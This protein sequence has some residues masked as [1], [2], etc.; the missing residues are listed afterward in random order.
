MRERD[1]QQLVVEAAGYLGWR[2][3]HDF[4]SR[5]STPGFPDLILVKPPR[6]LA[7]ELKTQR[8]KVR[9]GQIEWLTDLD[10]VPGV[11]ALLVRPA[12][13]DQIEALLRDEAA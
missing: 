10:Q 8:G 13:W 7:L 2:V 3:F 4:D 5:R 12:D 9:P 6:L 1:F 11:T